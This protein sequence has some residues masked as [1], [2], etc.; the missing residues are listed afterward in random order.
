M[1]YYGRW[2]YKYEIA[3]EKGRGGRDPGP[4][5]RAGGLSVRG[6]QGELEP[7]E[8]RHRRSR[9]RSPAPAAWPSRAGSPSRRPRNCSRP[10]ATTSTR[11]SRPPPQR[12][13]RPVPLGRRRDF[14][15][16]N[17][18][19]EVKSQ[20]RRRQARRVRPALKD[21]TRDLHGPLG[22]PRP[23]PARSRAT[24]SST[25]P[26]TTPRASPPCWRSPARS[27]RSQPAP[28]RSILFLAVTAE[29]KG[30]ARR[31]VLRRAP[32]LSARAT[33]ADINMDV[34]NLWGPTSDII[35]IGMGNST[36]DDLLVEIAARARPHGR[37][38][39][40][41]REGLLLTAPTTSS[42]PSRAC[43]RSIPRGGVSTSA[44][45]PTSAQRKHDEYTDKDYHKVSD[46]VKPDWDL[47]GAVEDLGSWPRSAI[48][49]PRG[50]VTPSGSPAA[51][52]APS[53]RRCS[54]RPNHESIARSDRSV[55]T[56]R[57]GDL[58]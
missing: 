15:V 18:L 14:A 34:I 17:A 13:F 40:R 24:R 6:R 44:S 57:T 49:W 11:S 54:R 8:L 46:E 19:R 28:K 12:D 9:R 25:A 10:A 37:P 52:S 51:S 43:P 27:P 36:L 56:A 20:E 5:D 31:Q 35:S 39:R 33:L 48:A 45:P 16:T 21:E 23:R 50:T 7:R 30:S 38:R 3:S 58:D 26:R 42:S 29:E 32:A 47:S 53:A 55:L 41:A 4:R 22:P 1:T 2:T